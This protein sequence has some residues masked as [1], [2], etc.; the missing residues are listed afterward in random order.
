MKTMA[1][2]ALAVILLL[3]GQSVAARGHAP[4]AAELRKMLLDKE[5][6]LHALRKEIEATNDA[7]VALIKA[8]LETTEIAHNLESLEDSV[9]AMAIHDEFEP[10]KTE[11]ETIR[12]LEKRIRQQRTHRDHAHNHYT[13]ALSRYLRLQASKNELIR[14]KET[15]FTDMDR[16]LQKLSVQNNAQVAEQKNKKGVK[17]TP[18]KKHHEKTSHKKDTANPRAS[19]WTRLGLDK[20][21]DR[22]FGKKDEELTPARK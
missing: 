4:E 15:L 18:S 21:W 8:E 10:A 20:Y 1:L 6:E 22:W 2:K 19:L 14:R 3:F 17:E 7:E 11:S 12:A 9:R 13:A 5:D 16:L